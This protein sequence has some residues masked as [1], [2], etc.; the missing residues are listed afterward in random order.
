[1]SRPEL[2]T[3]AAVVRDRLGFSWNAARRMCRSGRVT[4]GG[5]VCDDPAARVEAD[6]VD[7]DPTAP[8]RRLGVL[9]A[10]RILF[11]DGHVAV[12]DKPAG[13]LSVP[14]AG[15]KDTLVDQLRAALRRRSKSFDPPVG[16]VHRLDK[17][18]SGVLV[19]A[20]TLAAK[21]HLAGL[22]RS[23]DIE[24]RYVA[25]AHGHAGVRRHESWLVANRGDGLRGSYGVARPAQGKRP[26]EAR[27]A[28][29]YVVA[30]EPLKR[31][32]RIELQ[33]ETGRQHQIR[34]HLAEAGHPLVGEPVY[35]RDFKGT[36]VEAP[37]PM[38]HAFK[39]GFAHPVSGEIL[40]FEV[41][42]PPDFMEVLKRLQLPSGDER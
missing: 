32:C 1:M 11:A 21:R 36:P 31:A 17:G 16:V 7:V 29:T 5:E 27:R 38:L 41:P 22:F 42:P 25:L 10:E 15:E 8:K 26:R 12:V 20:R 35:I 28:V 19:F 30:T 33:L 13:M 24:R 18:T 39:L 3:L 34:I 37:R 40:R 4:V 9:S 23:H 2:P 6:Q 14:Y